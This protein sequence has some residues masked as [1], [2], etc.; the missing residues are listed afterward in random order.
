MGD[1]ITWFEDCP[2]CGDKDSVE[3]YD[4]SSANLYVGTCDSCGWS[5][6]REYYQLSKYGVVLLTPE[7]YE[8]LIK[9]EK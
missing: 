9:K 2:K 8:D 1:R 6:P 7:E 4:H 5:D 3:Y